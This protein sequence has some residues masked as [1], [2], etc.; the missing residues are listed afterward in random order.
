MR[1]KPEIILPHD[2]V[3]ECDWKL[4][5]T[6]FKLVKHNSIIYLIPQVGYEFVPFK[7]VY[8]IHSCQSTLKEFHKWDIL[9]TGRYQSL[10]T[11]DLFGVII[12]WGVAPDIAHKHSS[13][14]TSSNAVKEVIDGTIIFRIRYF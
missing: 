12:A 1:I 3:T 8:E 11:S 7:N 10:T 9:T 14:F 4:N 2:R 13:F 5:G 6:H